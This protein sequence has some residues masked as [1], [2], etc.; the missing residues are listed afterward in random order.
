M[1]LIRQAI[2]VQPLEAKQRLDL[3]M[4]RKF[5]VIGR[6]SWQKRI[7]EG[8]VFVNE[9]QCRPSRRISPGE[10][11]EFLYERRPE[12]PVDRNAR[13]LMDDPS[14]LIVDK[15]ANLP[16]HPSGVYFQN[17]LYYVLK[18]KFGADFKGY[19]AHRLDRETSGLLVL[20]RDKKS[21]AFLQRAFRGGQVIK[22]YLTIVHG[23]FP[24]YLEAAGYLSQGNG[25]VRKRR[26]FTRIKRSVEGEQTAHSEFTL[27]SRKGG[28][29]LILVRLHT[30]RMH[31]IRATLSSLGFPVAGDRLYGLDE[32]LYLKFIHGEETDEDRERLILG[33]S[34]LHSHRLCFEHPEK[35][36]SVDCRSEMPEDMRRVME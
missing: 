36:E 6:S 20:G 4:S 35:K 16:V 3:F 15:P 2:I 27:V 23:D 14:F 7:L 18:E 33:R 32:N 19:F 25:P 34:A 21:A 8:L 24:E 5:P 30:G 9:L 26:I 22:E 11:V 10:K 29:S 28:L 12:P 1:N 31:Q 17:T 13:I